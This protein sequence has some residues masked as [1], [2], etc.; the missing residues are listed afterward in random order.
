MI[1]AAWFIAGAVLL[2]VEF[3]T[4][5]LLFASL[6]VSALAAAGVGFLGGDGVWTSIAFAVTGLLTLVLLRP[7]GLRAMRRSAQPNATNVDALIGATARVIDTV[8][9]D[10][11]RIKLRGEE[12][13]ARTDSETITEGDDVIVIA[14]VGA[15]AMVARKENAS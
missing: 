5:N 8:T 11:G 1:G 7:L 3:W 15:T 4:A 10:S 9:S 6:G 14:I 13:T 2:L 12:W